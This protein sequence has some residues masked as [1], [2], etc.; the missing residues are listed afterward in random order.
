MDKNKCP[1]PKIVLLSRKKVVFLYFGNF[2]EIQRF[3]G[4]FCGGENKVMMEDGGMMM[5]DG[6]GRREQVK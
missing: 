2:Q 3:L 4:I 6:E 1:K 5:E